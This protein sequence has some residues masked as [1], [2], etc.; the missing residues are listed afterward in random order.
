MQL[1]DIP[2]TIATAFNITNI[3]YPGVDLLSDNIPSDRVRIFNDYIWS[4]NYWSKSRVP[5]ITK[6]KITGPLGDPRSWNRKLTSFECDESIDF[7][8]TD[9]QKYYSGYM[10]LQESWG[11]WSDGSLAE[12]KFKTPPRCEAKSLTFN[13]KA[14]VTPKNSEQ[15]ASVVINDKPV[16]D[17]RISVGEAQPKQFTFALPDTQDNTYTV[18]FEIDKP[19]T[20][21]SVGVN[22]DMRELGFGFVSMKLLADE[23]V[24]Q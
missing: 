17:I 9:Y 15:T 18:R 1:S 3:S 7:S 20:P 6:Y 10:G 8:K 22:E 11:R 2:K 5:P 24:A 23:V 21:K 12:V 19:T 13:L 4:N 14:F 16:G